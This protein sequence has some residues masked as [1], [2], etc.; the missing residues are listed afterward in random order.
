MQDATA[1]K[2]A[3]TTAGLIICCG[4]ANMFSSLLSIN[5]TITLCLKFKA[6]MQH[7]IVNCQ[8]C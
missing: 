5:T 8:I 1:K 4:L 2:K 7:N 6:G 3:S